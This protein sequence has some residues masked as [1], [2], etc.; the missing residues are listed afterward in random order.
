MDRYRL[1]DDWEV[2][3]LLNL[4][5]GETEY[6]EYKSSRI[7]LTNLKE[8]IA[9]AASAFWNS[10]G[11]IFIAGVDDQGKVDGGLAEVVGRQKIRDWT[12]QILASIE[13]PG[14][15]AIKTIN[16][17]SITNP[18]HVVLVISFGESFNGPHMAPDKKYYI[19]AGTHSGPASHYLVEAIRARRGLQNP[20]LRGLIRMHP[21]KDNV[22][23][24]VVLNIAESP[25]LNV[26]ITFTPLPNA[27]A[28]HTANKF[29]LVIPVISRE[30]SFAMDV[31]LW[32]AG[33]EI[34]GTASVLLKMKYNNLVGR[35]FEDA[36]S[37]HPDQSLGPLRFT[38][39]KD[40]KKLIEHIANELKH[41]RRAAESFLRHTMDSQS[42]NNEGE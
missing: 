34:F 6:Y 36:Q 2:E 9:I 33:A 32:G 13:P 3:D 15:Y 21:Q 37:L 35:V 8:K 25:A 30:Q 31:S 40:T 17:I 39:T 1:I 24:L 11:G 16:N 18:N 42:K 28:E 20:V 14:S 23:Q 7:P 29:P 12:D 26:E 22:V 10:G 5:S 38:D 4:P 19:R 27:F 41:L